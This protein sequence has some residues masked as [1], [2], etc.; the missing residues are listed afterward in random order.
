MPGNPSRP[1]EHPELE[2]AAK[3]W[4]GEWWKLGGGGTVW[5]SIAYPTEVHT[6]YIG[7]G[8]GTPWS[9]KIRSRGGGDNQF[10]SSI[11]ALYSDTGR[12][13]R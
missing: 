1:F 8:N 6:G 10:L 13:K 2:L 12:I 5:N 9:R 4:S 7:V 11:A 3:T